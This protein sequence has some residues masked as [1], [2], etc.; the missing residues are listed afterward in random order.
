MSGH[1]LSHYGTA[2]VPKIL[3]AVAL[4]VVPTAASAAG[5]F[6]CRWAPLENRIHYGAF[7]P[8]DARRLDLRVA[9]QGA[10]L[11]EDAQDLPFPRFETPTIADHEL[12]TPVL[13]CHD[14]ENEDPHGAV[15]F[16]FLSQGREVGTC[17]VLYHCPPGGA[18]ARDLTSR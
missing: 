6:F 1:A 16:T 18:L 2:R 12:T 10:I 9:M 15:T 14:H 7:S 3:L 11:V 5:G 13:L 8:Q 4:L 17:R